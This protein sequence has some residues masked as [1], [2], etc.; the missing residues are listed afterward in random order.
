MTLS[1]DSHMGGAVPVIDI[2]KFKNG[3]VDVR[4]NMAS[5]VS[6]A[7]ERTGFFVIKGHGFHPQVIPSLRDLCWQFFDLP[8]AE[9]LKLRI[10]RAS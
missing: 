6:S 4:T 9:K 8:L 7:L 1:K 10:H 5:A 3:K 2:S